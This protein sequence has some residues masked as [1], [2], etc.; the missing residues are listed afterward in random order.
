M[1]LTIH[2]STV[3][4]GTAL[5]LAFSNSATFAQLSLTTSDKNIVAAICSNQRPQLPVLTGRKKLLLAESTG[6]KHD[7]H[8]QLTGNIKANSINTT[9]AIVCLDIK[10]ST[11]ETCDFGPLFPGIPRVRQD[12]SL[13][14][15]SVEPSVEGFLTYI[16]EGEV[17]PACEN[18]GTI[19]S[20]VT[21]ISGALP[22]SELVYDAL[23]SLMLT[24]TDTDDDGYT[25]LE[26]FVQGSDL[27]DAGSPGMEISVSANNSANLIIAEGEA[28]TLSISLNPGTLRREQAKYYLY[29]D[30]LS[31]MFSYFFPRRFEPVDTRQISA[32]GPALRFNDV[33]IIT[34]PALGVGDYEFT[35]DVDIN[36]Q[37]SLSSS[38]KISVVPNN[39][40]FTEVSL[41]SGID[42]SHGYAL[43]NS[44]SSHDRRTNTAGVA[45]GDYDQDG[46]VDLYIVRGTVGPNQ[47]FRNL[48]N[49]TF[50]E[51]GAEA[52]VDL[53]GQDN[54]AA[55]FADYD[56][57]GFL[58]LIV[59]GVNGTQVT[60]FR[61]DGDGTFTDITESSGI[62]EMPISMGVSF[63]DY[64]KDGD[65]DLW[66][67]HWLFTTDQGYLW[68]NNGD[69]TFTDASLAAGIPDGL[70]ADF[71]TN[72]SDINND[73]WLD[74]LISGDY[75]SSQILT[76]DKD[77][78]FTLATTDVISDENGMGG[79]VGDYDNDGDLDWFVTSVYDFRTTVDFPWGVT[80]N[81]FYQN[82]GQGNFTDVT[83]VTGT[84][85]GYWGWG[86]CFADFNNDSWLDLFH[87]NGFSGG[88]DSSLSPFTEDPSQLYIS[89]K[90]GSFLERS[91]ELE[92]NDQGQGRGIVC[93]D[94]DRDG[95]I[96]IFV[97]N[98]R[99]APS[100]FRNDSN[101]MNNYLHIQLEGEDL[102]SEAVG[103][104][105]YLT[106][107]GLTQMRELRAGS[108]Y[109]S[110]N[111]VEAYFG[112]GTRDKVAEVRV[113]WPSGAEKVL[114][115]VNAN[116]LLYITHP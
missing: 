89:D 8:D 22:N 103:A 69:G 12:Y 51:S 53:S 68:R 105:I 42:Y 4:A 27:N 54:A 48:G 72:F 63:A 94:Y 9:G 87:V 106:E 74:L 11:L 65:L 36:D 98:N 93:F 2:K 1:K 104:R 73:G 90:N 6:Q 39:W 86:A 101:D 109:L 10:Q 116:Q 107:N 59:T 61:N 43:S 7:L 18:A 82:D 5:I 97:A 102:N 38:A 28:I 57:D 37:T 99:Q 46:W 34:L 96:D 14:I 110:Q 95:D 108:N 41:A 32:Q 64:D 50:E 85:I 80:G 84:R 30:S 113:V 25:N 35:F 29:A 79:A 23:S 40:Q 26:E 112:L 100:L 114:E 75:G 77:G 44:G 45:A 16:V 115:N 55:T 70:T 33:Q 60:L 20:S 66:I 62:S 19:D 13:S 21:T 83:D 15:Y 49:G 17:P 91:F 111:P 58:D 71:T 56:G 31:G 76:N 92:L 24:A 81:R 78:T 88:G 67:N 52:G 47:L 3:L